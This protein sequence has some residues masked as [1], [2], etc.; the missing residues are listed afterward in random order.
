MCSVALAR[1]GAIDEIAERAGQ[2]HSERILPMIDGL[3]ARHLITLADCDAIAFGAGPGSF[4]GL[5]IACGIAQGLAW[6]ADKLVLPVSNLTALALCGADHLVSASTAAP[7]LI[8][9]AIDARLGECYWA[10][11]ESVDGRL[12]E[13]SAPALAAADELPAL[14][15]S[16]DIALLVGNAAAAFQQLRGIASHDLPIAA[17]G[18]GVIARLAQVDW[19]AGRAV[20]AAAAAPIYVRERVALTIDERHALAEAARGQATLKREV[21]IG[22]TS[23]ALAAGSR[24]TAARRGP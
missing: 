18:A 6:G 13:R 15:A 7:H 8:A 3:L 19:L 16:Y 20:R 10:L 12:R 14:L 2:T 9:V 5:R 22:A 11:F 21:T 1:D 23:D 4:T 24:V 17:A